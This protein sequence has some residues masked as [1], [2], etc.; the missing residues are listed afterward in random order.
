MDGIVLC[1]CC[2]QTVCL[3]SGTNP[4]QENPNDPKSLPRTADFTV[5]SFW[6][7]QNNN[8]QCHREVWVFMATS[9]PCPLNISYLC[10]FKPQTSINVLGLAEWLAHFPKE[11]CLAVI[12]LFWCFFSRKIDNIL[13]KSIS[14]TKL[15][16]KR[17]P[18]HKMHSDFPATEGLT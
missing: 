14:F 1:T 13:E 2:M 6:A 12:L 11:S 15:T 17:S 3:G 4:I 5:T 10:T 16:S 7:V 8:S 9:Y 18:L